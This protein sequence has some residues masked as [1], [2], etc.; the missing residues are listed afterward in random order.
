MVPEVVENR[1]VCV[2]VVDVVSVWRV[3]VVV[4]FFWRRNIPIEKWILGFG[5]II[6][7][8][9]SNDV[10]EKWIENLITF[11]SKTSPV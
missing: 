5:F 6:H 9:K 2:H 8:V 1:H 7:G 3:L 11:K 10:P 4:P